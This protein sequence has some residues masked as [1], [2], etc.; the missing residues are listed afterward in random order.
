M[1]YSTCR[2]ERT[3]ALRLVLMAQRW[4]TR[5]AHFLLSSTI[6]LSL[7]DMDVLRNTCR[8]VP[9]R[10]N[11]QFFRCL[12]TGPIKNIINVGNAVSNP[13]SLVSNVGTLI[14]LYY[15]TRIILSYVIFFERNKR[16]VSIGTIY[17]QHLHDLRG[18]HPVEH[19]RIFARF[20]SATLI[21]HPQSKQLL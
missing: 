6:R 17:H 7:S 15:R 21:R 1:P 16:L 19:K 2:V 4:I 20:H 14:R 13:P 11:A 18:K 10:T 5:L 8:S 3:T 9:K 12:S